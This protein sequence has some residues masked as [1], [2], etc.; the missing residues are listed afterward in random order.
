MSDL[1]MQLAGVMQREIDGLT[2]VAQ[3]TANA[4][5]VAYKASRSFASM[6][7]TNSN[8]T[9]SEKLNALVTDT[10]VILKDGALQQT[11]Q[12]TDL[13]LAGNGWFLVQIG[14]E[15]RITRDGRFQINAD[16]VLVNLAG[17]KV[18]GEQGDIRVSGDFQID[19]AGVI[20]VQNDVINQ[21]RV[22]TV[23]DEKAI[24]AQGDG[25][26]S[27]HSSLLRANSFTV[28]QGA[29]ERSNVDMSA[30]MVRLMETSRHIE[31]IQRALVAYDGLLNTGINQLGKE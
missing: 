19:Q 28:Y 11:G 21:L 14:Q 4:N 15:Q 5:T 27:F 30:N 26:Y 9:M 3:N 1:I 13:A 17:W 10:Q 12:S 20:R 22:V 25:L 8:M 29:Q 23:A 31:S 2:D 24:V 18:M 7:L 6:V 16:G